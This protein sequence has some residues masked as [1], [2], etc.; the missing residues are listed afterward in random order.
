MLG[1]GVIGLSGYRVI[2]KGE[3]VKR[4]REKMK[5]RWKRE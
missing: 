3:K 2:S 5:E 4:R 1:G